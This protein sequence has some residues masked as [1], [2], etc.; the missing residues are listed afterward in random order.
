MNNSRRILLTTALTSY[1]VLVFVLDVITP[2]GIEV[3]VLNLPVI[4][5]PV[6]LRNLRLVVFLTLASS[7]IVVFGSIFSPS[8]YNPPLWDILNRG[9]GLATVWLIAVM[10]ISFIKRT[11]QLDDAL[12]RLRRETAERE[13]IGR[14]LKQSEERL[15]L[16]MEGAGMG[17]FDVDLQTGKAAWSAT[18][19]RLLG[20][21]AMAGRE[22]T[23]DLCRS[24]IHSDDVARVVDARE[25]ARQGRSPYSV[26]YRIHRADSGEIAWLAVFGRFC[27]DDSGEAVRLLGV[28]FDI[29]R[30]KALEREAL[31]SEVLA[32]T[33][34]KQRQIGQELHDGVGQEL[35]G[36][37]LMAQSLAE[38]LPEAAAENH[39]ARRLLA[40]LDGLH[41]KVRE[42]A[43][44]LIPVH[45]ESMGLSA[46]LDDLATR[47]TEASG[48]SV[49]AECPDGVELADHATATELFYI[50]Q[51]AV[52][53]ALRHGRPRNIR[54]SLLTEPD[55]L[56][57]GIQDDGIGF[58]DGLE[59]TAGLGLR[60]M[61][62]RAGVIGGVLQIGLSP[63]GGTVV[64]CTL[65]RSK[66][67]DEKESGNW[68]GQSK[69]LGR[70]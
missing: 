51:E 15:R 18:H 59:Q 10:A 40:G 55:G 25:Q 34:R 4:L 46:A 19:F 31:Q 41:Q 36:L 21:E 8:G 49:T 50:A 12:S 3:W 62:H 16:A 45:V 20:Y 17:T 42:L 53:N 61:Q 47:T 29:T 69:N 6:L 48:I 35:T 37:G 63:G 39:I 9:M 70:G 33:A 43:R 44:G 14:A 32:M 27:Y 54:L 66:G 30:R 56:R 5:V 65:P 2:L 67:N 38:R 24:C 28:A 68:L 13:Q 7:A 23:T 60:I 26:E 57:L 64:T 11:I 1:S 22:T 58:R 52:G